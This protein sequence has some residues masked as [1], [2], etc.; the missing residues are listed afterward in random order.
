MG[1]YENLDQA[2]PGLLF[3]LNARRVIGTWRAAEEIGFGIP[4]FGYVGD[5]LNMYTAK[6]DIGIITLDADFVLDNT[7][8]TTLTIDGVAQTPVATPWN[9]D[10]DTTMDDHKDDLEAAFSGLEVTLTDGTTNRQFTLFWKGKNVEIAS[11]ITGGASQANI[12]ITYNNNQVFIGVTSFTQT[13]ST[14]TVGVNEENDPS[15]V[16]ERGQLWT[17]PQ[18]TVQANTPAYVIWQVGANQGKFTATATDNYETGCTFRNNTTS[19]GYAIV[20]V[21][22][23]NTDAT[24]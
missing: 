11:V 13:G 22:G 1:A 9:A 17:E 20:E 8:T 4:A 15:N 19:Q 6:Q 12:T 21:N 14:E 16:C 5:E 24:P 7:I 3:G 23:Q 18:G 10:H 2:F